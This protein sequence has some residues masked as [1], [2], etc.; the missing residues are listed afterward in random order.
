MIYVISFIRNFCMTIDSIV[1]WFIGWIYDIFMKITNVQFLDEKVFESFAQRIYIF[2]GII[3]LFKLSFSLLTYIVNPDNFT[4]KEKGFGKLVINIMLALLLIVI[5]PFLFSYSRNLQ[6]AILKDNIVPSIILG[7]D[8]KSVD[9]GKQG[10]QM[11]FM[12]FSTFFMPDAKVVE[13]KAEETAIEGGSGNYVYEY[14]T[15]NSKGVKQCADNLYKSS[16]DVFSPDSKQS[17]IN[18]NCQAFFNSDSFESV[19]FNGSDDYALGDMLDEAGQTQDLSL[20]M[21]NDLEN[22]KMKIGDKDTFFIDY[23]III[24]TIA[25]VM[26]AILFITFCIDIA[27]RTVKL[28][29][30]ELIAPIPIISYVDPKSSKSGMFNKWLKE[31]LKTYADLFVRLIAIFFA[32]FVISK[33]SEPGNMQYYDGMYKSDT[34]SAPIYIIV[35]LGALLF[36]KQLPKLI[37]NIIGIKMDGDFT[38]NP[39]KKLAKVPGMAKTIGMAG[40]IVAGAK[41]GREAGAG[42]KGA[43]WGGLSGSKGIT[44][45]DGLFGSFGKGATN[46]SK[47]LF[48]KDFQMFSPLDIM[49]KGKSTAKVENYE[50]ARNHFYNKEF[51]ANARATYYSEEAVKA[52]STGN[53]NGAGGYNELMAKA[54]N[55]KVEATKHAKSAKVLNDQMDDI[56]KFNRL[57][58]STK[59]KVDEAYKKYKIET[60]GSTTT[61][62]ASITG[63]GSQNPSASSTGGGSY[64][65]PAS[66]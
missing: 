27:I 54:N 26:I 40:G 43:I 37:E 42:I 13:A 58:D 66:T 38:M 5:V 22:I 55:A 15:D 6:K 30:L 25:G 24:S 17:S 51:D 10:E 45:K 59:I 9:I 34:V 39:T 63:V 56:K 32:L 47:A 44:E 33:M 18:D 20:L 49:P 35:M 21:K 52:Q 60:Q 3:M 46:S 53:I 57:D 8:K 61:R 36:A 28:A 29:F 2:L 50:K 11:A 1:Y 48:G 14:Y 4:D 16:Y 23:K 7:V 12:T 65:P 41:Y 64:N 19:K 31:C 62:G